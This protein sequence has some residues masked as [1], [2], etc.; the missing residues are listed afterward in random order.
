[1]DTISE[2]VSKLENSERNSIEEMRKHLVRLKDEEEKNNCLRE[3]ILKEITEEEK[4]V[5]VIGFPLGSLKESEVIDGLVAA[6]LRDDFKPD[7]LSVSIEIMWMKAQEGDK[8]SNPSFS[9]NEAKERHD[10]C[11]SKE[12]EPLLS[13]KDLPA[14]IPRCK[15]GVGANRLCTEKDVPEV[16]LY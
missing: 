5:I 13:E 2:R 3:K 14:E 1:M 10:P 6:M 15:E 9:W 8:K 7:S 16:Y 11:Q 12:R 4:C